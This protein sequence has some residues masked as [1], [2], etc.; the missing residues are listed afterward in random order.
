M[1]IDPF[2]NQ[3]YSRLLDYRYGY[4]IPTILNYQN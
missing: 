3:Y 4:L 1:T 2:D